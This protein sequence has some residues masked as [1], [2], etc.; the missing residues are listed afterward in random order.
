MLKEIEVLTTDKYTKYL[1][2]NELENDE[3]KLTKNIVLKPTEEN[4]VIN[5]ILDEVKEKGLID[6][7]QIDI[8]NKTNDEL[9]SVLK[10][11]LND[12]YDALEAKYSLMKQ[13]IDF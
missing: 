2:D 8:N 7:S 6:T 1:T 13:I 11:T 5:H 3:H 4:F 12:K 9:K 10:T